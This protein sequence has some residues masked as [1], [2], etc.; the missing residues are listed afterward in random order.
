MRKY[1]TIYEE[2]VSH[3]WL[4]TQSLGISLF[5]KENFILFFIS[6]HT[7]LKSISIFCNFYIPLERGGGNG[8]ERVGGG[9]G[10]PWDLWKQSGPVWKTISRRLANGTISI[11]LGWFA[12]LL[13][14][15][16]QEGNRGNLCLTMLLQYLGDLQEFDTSGQRRTNYIVRPTRMRSNIP[17]LE[18]GS[19]R[20]FWWYENSE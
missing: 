9:G 12:T 13:T 11:P 5:M 19:P 20:F 2:A 15:L 4:C 10:D 8:S 18:P 6:A 3:I 16:P 1:F 14:R 17:L 7:H